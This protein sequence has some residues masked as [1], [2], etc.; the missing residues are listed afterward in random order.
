MTE[1]PYMSVWWNGTQV[2]N[3][4]MVTGTAAGLSNHS[5]EEH[6]DPALYGLKLQSEGRDVRFRNVWIKKLVLS[7]AQTNLGY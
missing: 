7:Q 4:H 1:S 3:N 5:G 2:H 6:N